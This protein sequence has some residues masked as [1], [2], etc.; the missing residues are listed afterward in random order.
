MFVMLFSF[1][2]AAQAT[3]YQP[4]ETLEP[5]CAPSSDNCGV[6]TTIAVAAGGTGITSY[7]IGDLLYASG[8]NTLSKLAIGANN[9]VLKVSGGEIVW[10]SSVSANLGD[11]DLTLTGQR[12]LDL[13]GHSLTIQGAGGS[14]VFNNDGTING[15]A[16]NL[17]LARIG[18][19]TFST[20]QDLQNVF[21]SAGYTSGGEI[22]DA[23]GE[24]VNVAAG[25]GLLR[26]SNT[27]VATISYMDWE[28]V[29]NIAIPTN[30][31][32][33]IGIEYNGGSP[34][35]SVRT[36]SNWNLKTDFS[37]G[38]VVNEGGVLN[39]F[40]DKQA[41]GDHAANM[42]Q[43]DYETMP[44]EPDVRNGGLVFSETG[45]RNIAVTSGA[46]WD[47]LNRYTI[48]T[49]N[50]SIS[51][52]F[53]AY[54][55]NGSGGF[56]KV[57]GL[58]QWPNTKYDDE[59]GTL[60]T[61]TDGKYG[62]LWFYLDTNA[63][64]SMI[65]GMGEHDTAGLANSEMEL[66]VDMLPARLSTFGKLIGK[67][68]FQK[69]ASSATNAESLIGMSA[70]SGG[71]TSHSG[72]SDLDYAHS[73]HTGFADA[74]AGINTNITSATGLSSISST[75]TLDITATGTSTW[76][77][78][79][80]ALT[81]DSGAALNLG[82]TNA[83]SLN[84]GKVG[85][86][87][88][89]NGNLS[90]LGNFITPKGTDY[91]TTGSQNN[92][93]LG[94][95]SYFLYTGSG[96]ATFTGIAGG[97]DG[98]QIRIT[99]TSS[100]DLTITNQDTGSS[101][102][103]RII[104]PSSSSVVVSQNVTVGFEYDAGASR[105]RIVTLPA[106]ASAISAFAFL[107]SGNAF[108]ATASLGTTDANG[109]NFITGGATRFAVAAGSATLTGTGA[110][111]I[112][113]GS[114]LALSSAAASGLTVTAGS[115]GVLTLDSGSTGAVNLG[116][117]ANA[118]TITIGNVTGATAVN[119]NTGTG[120]STY[121]TT[122]GA[123]TLN[124]GTGA[125]NLG[126]D[127]V[128]KN[129]TLGNSTGTTSLNIN[130]GSGGGIFTSL[131][132]LTLAPYGASPGNTTEIRF[133]EL[134][135]NGSNYIGFKAP[136]DLI[137][138]A[139]WTLPDADGTAGQVLKTDGLKNLSWGTEG[140]CPNC[141]VSS[142]KFIM[143]DNGNII[144]LND[145]D[146]AFPSSQGGSGDVLT[147][148]G[149]GNLTWSATG[150]GSAALSGVTG[151]TGNAT[152]GNGNNI[153]NWN[154]AL[155]SSTNGLNISETVASTGTGYLE[156]IATLATSLAK[157]FG[158]A[159]RGTTI[160]D[161]TAAGGL[162]LGDSGTLNT[163]ITLQSGSGAINIGVDAVAH[164]ITLGNTTGATTLNL[165]SGSGGLNFGGNSTI[166]GSNTFTTGSGLTTINSTAV[167][168]AG[169]SSVIDMS[170]TGA[171]GLNTVTNRDIN[172]GSGLLT[173]GG[174]L[175]ASG[176]IIG[177]AN[178][179]VIGNFITPKG[180]DYLTTGSQNDVDLGAGSY[181]LYAGSGIATFTGIAGGVDGRQIRITNTSSSNL[182][183][184]H[185]DAGS[186]A[187]NRIITPSASSVVISQNVTIGLEYD[188]G[189]SRWRVVTLP[190]SASAI[191]GFAFLQS[192][193]AFG[194]TASLGTT[195]ANGLNFITGGATRFAVA[196]GSAT[197]TGTGA[198]SIGSSASLS[199]D[200]TTGLSLGTTNATS[201]S[202]GR[203]GITTTNSGSLTATQ[204]LT[205]S[206]GLTLSTGA[207][208]LAASSG[209]IDIRLAS[210]SG[211]SPLVFEGATV[212]GTNKTTFAMTEPTG[213]RTITFPDASITVNAA[214]N[215]S[216]ATLA[217]NVVNSSLTGV[218]AL[219][220][221]SITSGFGAIATTNNLTTSANISTT[222]SGT[223]T[224]A[225]TFTA[226]N[227]LT[228][229][230]GALNLTASSGALTLSGLSASSVSSGANNITFTSGNFNTTA[231]GINSTAIGVTTKATGAFTS[232]SSSG[233]T[234]LANAG[235]SNVTIATTGTG[236]VTIGNSTGTFA[237]TSSGGLNVTTGGAL[238]GVTSID[239]IT[240]SSTTIG[241]VGAGSISSGAATN[242]TLNSGT[243][244]NLT[245]DSGS[246][247][248]VLIGTGV[249]A[250]TI[251][252]GNASDDTFSLN[253]SGLSVTSAGALSGVTS[254]GA[255]GDI[256][257]SANISTTGSG[258]ITSAGTLTGSSSISITGTWKGNVSTTATSNSTT[259]STVSTQALMYY[260]AT[261]DTTG[262]CATASKTFNITGLT[263]AEGSYAYIVTKAIDGGC[264]SSSMTL[265]LQIN[266]VT[267]STVANANTNG[268]VTENYV[269]AYTNGAWRIL[270]TAATADGADLAENYATNDETIEA[271]DLVSLDPNLR[272]GVKKTSGLDDK[273][274][275]GI[276]STMPA[277]V[278][279]GL[280]DEGVTAL[281][282]ALSG[283][284]PVKVNAENGPIVVGDYLTPSSVPG[285]AMKSNGSGVVIGQAMSPFDGN[286]AGMVLAFIKNFDLGDIGQIDLVLGDISA[287]INSD[288]GDEGMSLFVAT[289]QAEAAREPIMIIAQ[290]I[291]DGKQFLTDFV[292]ARVTAIRGYFDEVFAKKVHTNEL[293]VKKSDG[294]EICVNGDQ[295]NTL[296]QDAGAAPAASTG[297][298]QAP[299]V[300]EQ[301]A[302]PSVP[303]EESAA[304][305]PAPSTEQAGDVTTTDSVVPP[306]EAV[307]SEQAPA[308]VSE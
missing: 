250:K 30:S 20:L 34:Q 273:S 200:A 80:G 224:S 103:N 130:A 136:D 211:A 300:T 33:Y 36:S 124:T 65:Y 248:S 220:V 182:T 27:A 98:R 12:V 280:S 288:G 233:A 258:A 110:T 29:N 231:T 282:V 90:I 183:F 155:S 177:N 184:A 111:S 129:I 290:K 185:Q 198:T 243:T 4:G 262:T 289:V 142:T 286:E 293:C 106:S 28:A 93:N 126:T 35:I 3:M 251:T 276:I 169:N 255:S 268:T 7:S 82:T 295:I 195:D 26:S 228:Q 208:N 213:V 120:G 1:V 94:A 56:T 156:K 77:T 263:A 307:V 68:V 21:H 180:A 66:S 70:D 75:T 102:A 226:S 168:L 260:V 294:S 54:Y 57:T 79:G 24:A 6:T 97:T 16:Q 50:T 15:N 196:A 178:L 134:A 302:A 221:G 287:K 170:G 23:G 271:G 139:I 232:L 89:N 176:N 201:V 267:I 279:G 188:A 167:T 210:I 275:V 238:T 163:P 235:A 223:M 214:G 10:G 52:N 88:V 151:A 245:I 46:I 63:R 41:V 193:N 166:T 274:V 298:A 55:M 17:V 225:G 25:T 144:K 219:S 141:I 118:K 305:E 148:D 186:L 230:T 244:G 299:V 152:I 284:V 192:G 108:G 123:F 83:S 174:A 203:T 191:S 101:A 74:I 72:L 304:L 153:I 95:G 61:L 272:A 161:T 212:D 140:A 222:G 297:A 270:G 199:L 42:V 99:N 135:A 92:V 237:L 291:T 241:F 257:T 84:L 119:I 283:R 234:D 194:A 146:I 145:V 62:V 247:G 157:P 137:G 122:N 205:A 59:S 22:T 53:D 154:W 9:Q 109:L 229:T 58:T 18:N 96:S 265:T 86:T 11:T 158:I 127:A 292:S 76:S 51:G 207:L 227:G 107:Q 266:G 252:I 218:G 91:S 303:N 190:A 187:A 215:I 32:R 38:V 115:T 261:T 87:T 172:T 209:A 64:I 246:T 204:T 306:V 100:S 49:F 189:A 39:I 13:D 37:L 104:T 256:S 116:T 278:I 150:A 113:G 117:G 131:A 281:P 121:T 147:N 45:T 197:L 138:N 173:T 236:N 47:R 73:G 277:M 175:T 249:N 239:T 69:N 67:I 31:V 242:L 165:S 264:N 81:L 301:E 78:S 217:S 48:P 216:G 159:A 269:V 179:S 253:S 8:V 171:L 133:A 14:T 114:T 206:N 202:I 160:F 285:V 308:V 296:L 5:D 240:H 143:N 44:L 254:I 181:F 164:T 132:G 43:R 112:V 128:A 2:Y 162:T 60:A 40:S 125:I 19:S 85:V 259:I 71:V 105:W 149:A